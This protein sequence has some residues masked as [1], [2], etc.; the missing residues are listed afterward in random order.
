MKRVI[1]FLIILTCSPKLFCQVLGQDKEGFSTIIQPSA[2]FNLDLSEK[3]ATLN[4]YRQD[5]LSDY[6]DEY[7][8]DTEEMC[9]IKSN[10][11][12]EFTKCLKESWKDQKAAYKKLN[13]VY[14]IDLKGSSSDGIALLIEDEQV[15]TSSRLSGLV[16]LQW[17][18]RRYRFGKIDKISKII[19]EYEDD[20]SIKDKE[21]VTA[22]EKEVDL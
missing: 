17:Q 4:Y 21:L 19:Y 18:K 16:G 6:N 7:D 5:N 1:F 3:V 10:S 22:I 2:T 13:I 14:G 20:R 11:L 9:R 12:K 8:F 15:S